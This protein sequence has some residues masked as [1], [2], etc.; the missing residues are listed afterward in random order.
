MELLLI[1]SAAKQ[2]K[3]IAQQIVENGIFFPATID[4]SVAWRGAALER[5]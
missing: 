3:K 2:L 5:A 1:L 4:S